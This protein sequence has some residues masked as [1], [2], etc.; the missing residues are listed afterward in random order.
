[1]TIDIRDISEPRVA[2]NAPCISCGDL[3]ERYVRL[4]A[5][6]LCIPCHHEFVELA[7][8]EQASEFYSKYL[9]KYLG[10]E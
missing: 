4:G 5:L 2:W 7:T 1:M 9:K 8:L 10:G 3:H 6:P